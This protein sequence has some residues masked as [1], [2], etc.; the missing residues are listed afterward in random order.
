MNVVEPKLLPQDYPRANYL[1]REVEHARRYL[2]TA[3]KLGETDKA[4]LLADFLEFAWVWNA[5]QGQGTPAVHRRIARWLQARRDGGDRRLL[6]T[7]RDPDGELVDLTGVDLRF[8]A[9]NRSTD[10]DEDAL[11]VWAAVEYRGRGANTLRAIL[12]DQA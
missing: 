6:L 7:V 3:G 11:S 4:E 10:L 2:L 8:M 9:K 5:A 12:E 1:K